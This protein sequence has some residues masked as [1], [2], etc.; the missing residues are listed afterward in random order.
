MWLL[1]TKWGFSSW[2]LFFQKSMVFGTQSCHMLMMDED[3]DEWSF[4]WDS[5]RRKNGVF[6]G[7]STTTWIGGW[8]WLEVISESNPSVTVIRKVF[9]SPKWP[10]LAKTQLSCLSRFGGFKPSKSSSLSRKSWRKLK[11]HSKIYLFLKLVQ[12]PTEGH[13]VINLY[14]GWSNHANVILDVE[15]IFWL[16][17]N[18]K[19][20][21]FFFFRFPLK[22]IKKVSSP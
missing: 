10:F 6:Q 7:T 14:W 11:T 15:W 16:S 5:H 3:H 18:K 4:T 1:S 22:K 19:R 8:W 12:N 20:I 21:P 17:I 9:P 2:F 13:W